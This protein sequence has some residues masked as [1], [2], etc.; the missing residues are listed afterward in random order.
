MSDNGFSRNQ[1]PHNWRSAWGRE[2]LEARA[3]KTERAHPPGCR[4][5]VGGRSE[6]AGKSE[7]LDTSSCRNGAIKGDCVE[8]SPG[9][10]GFCAMTVSVG[11]H[12]G[13]GGGS[14]RS[15]SPRPNSLEAELAGSGRESA[16]KPVPAHH[17]RSCISPCSP[18]G[19]NARSL[20]STSSVN[21]T[22]P[23]EFMEKTFYIFASTSTPP[24]FRRARA[25]IKIYSPPHHQ[26]YSYQ[27]CK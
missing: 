6:L 22:L 21:S 2:G 13:S 17:L 20:A 24:K 25:L 16:D 19:V 3:G 18:F 26:S 5:A 1:T 14:T 11:L 12:Q 4:S 27:G 15:D 23:P 10:Y 9:R 8:R 7:K